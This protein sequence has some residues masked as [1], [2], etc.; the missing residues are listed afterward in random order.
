MML[1][2]Q[3]AILQAEA[4][5]VVVKLFRSRYGRSAVAER[6][7]AAALLLSLGAGDRSL[8]EAVLQLLL[9]IATQ[10]RTCSYRS[11][12]RRCFKRRLTRVALSLMLAA[13]AAIALAKGG[14]HEL[15]TPI[16]KGQDSTNAPIAQAI[17]RALPKVS[18]SHHHHHHHHKTTGVG[19]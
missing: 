6:G 9:E 15:L 10:D 17:L 8:R 7:T 5:R 4:F 16:A 3:F 1:A 11:L 2:S 19:K 13:S 12:A 14:A 18:S